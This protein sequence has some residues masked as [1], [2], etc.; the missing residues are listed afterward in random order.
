MNFYRITGLLTL[1]L[2]LAACA[3]PGAT[4]YTLLPDSI[5]RV[6]QPES[7][8][9]TAPYAM[10]VQVVEVPPEVDRPQIVFTLPDTAQVVPLNTALW[11]SPLSDQIRL[12]MVDELS[13]RLH[14]LDTASSVA[15]LDLPLW[16]INLR[17]H[18]FE[19]LYKQRS[20]LDVSWLLTPLNIANATAKLCGAQIQ[21]PVQDTVSAMVKG[22]QQALSELSALIAAQLKNQPM[23]LENSQVYLKG[24]TY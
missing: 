1:T 19:S 5:E 16:K 3:T 23:A 6:T 4:Y 17:V 12:A 20:T 7:A 9:A 18:R 10:S 15:A 2:M 11:A 22:H 8:Q 14:T 21:T 13:R 24:C